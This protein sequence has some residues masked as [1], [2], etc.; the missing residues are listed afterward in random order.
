MLYYAET[1]SAGS[2]WTF[3]GSKE[4][5]LHPEL[6]LLKPGSS[7]R[8]VELDEAPGLKLQR[9]GYTGLTS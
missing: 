1:D 6:Q 8:V 9:Q 4:I 3:A 7:L 5:A 2:F